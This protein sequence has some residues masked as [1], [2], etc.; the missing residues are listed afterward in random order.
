MAI[1]PLK[2]RPRMTSLAVVEA[3]K[4]EPMGVCWVNRRNL[5]ENVRKAWFNLSELY[6]T[7]RTVTPCHPERSEGSDSP[8]TEILRCAQ[9]DS[10]W[11]TVIITWFPIIGSLQFWIPL[12]SGMGRKNWLAAASLSCLSCTFVL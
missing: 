11:I 10:V 1:L 7:V 12:P 5:L 8:G 9:D 3:P 2:S 6:L 4:P